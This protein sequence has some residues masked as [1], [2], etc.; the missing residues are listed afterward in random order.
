M[1]IT[2]EIENIEAMRRLQGIDDAELHQEIRALQKG[3]C[4]K[5]TLLPLN[6]ASSGDLLGIKIIRI[7]GNSFRGRLAKK[8]ALAEL[9]KL[10]IGSLISFSA[11]H[12]HSIAKESLK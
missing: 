8:P 2:M 1:R 11:D 3:D 12:I 7:E 4:V 6:K 5:L 9:R 10:R